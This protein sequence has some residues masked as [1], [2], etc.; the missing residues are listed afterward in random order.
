MTEPYAVEKQ[1]PQKPNL[2]GKIKACNLN[3]R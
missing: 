2:W 1:L 3:R